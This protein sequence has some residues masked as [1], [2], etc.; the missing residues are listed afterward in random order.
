MSRTSRISL[1]SLVHSFSFTLARAR[2]RER[3]LVY[4]P[5]EPSLSLSP[6]LLP[7]P[8]SSP[9]P[10]LPH[11]HHHQPCASRSTSCSRAVSSVSAR[12]TPSSSLSRKRRPC[13]CR[14]P[15]TWLAPSRPSRLRART[16]PL[17]RHPHPSYT[18]RPFSLAPSHPL[19]ISFSLSPPPISPPRLVRYALVRVSLL[20]RLSRDSLAATFSVARSVASL[21]PTRGPP[22]HS[23]SVLRRARIP[24]EPLPRRSS[25]RAESVLVPVGEFRGVL[26]F[27][28]L[29]LLLAAT[30][31]SP[32]PPHLL[33]PPNAVRPQHGAPNAISLS[34]GFAA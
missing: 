2:A 11:Y 19:P 22:A 21:A 23:L 13:F 14:A 9:P 4:V 3:C 7:P 18:R 34:L 1:S 6:A 12:T 26:L 15:Q 5:R 29:L 20:L 17:D 8:P 24:R 10:P 32:L 28:R 31:C 33:A 16:P 30:S 25:A 27:L